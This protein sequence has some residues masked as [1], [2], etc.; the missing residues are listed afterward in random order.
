MSHSKKPTDEPE[1]RE[2]KERQDM[3][4]VLDAARKLVDVR[5]LQESMR[6]RRPAR[7]T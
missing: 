3:R 5:K 4:P 2:A 6:K 7:K 1:V